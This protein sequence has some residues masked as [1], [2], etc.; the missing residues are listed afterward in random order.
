M[1]EQII[2]SKGGLEDGETFIEIDQELPLNFLKRLFFQVN[3]L[4]QFFEF[5]SFQHLIYYNKLGSIFCD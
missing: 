3:D 5:L 4:K 2:K 1:V